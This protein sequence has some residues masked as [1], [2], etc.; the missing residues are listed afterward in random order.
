VQV[1]TITGPGPDAVNSVDD[2]TVVATKIETRELGAG[3]T[4]T[5][6]L[7]ALSVN[8]FIFEL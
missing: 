1:H 3:P 4:Y 7:P 2:R 5:T 6:T 8:A